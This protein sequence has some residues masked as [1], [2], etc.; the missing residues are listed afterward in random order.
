MKTDGQHFRPFA[1]C[2]FYAPRR[3]ASISPELSKLA[4]QLKHIK[5]DLDY[6]YKKTSTIRVKLKG[7]FPQAF[8]STA[9]E[10][11]GARE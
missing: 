8:A 1:M 9:A 10:S 7:K 2:G 3:Y 5:N 11:E 6:I 4:K